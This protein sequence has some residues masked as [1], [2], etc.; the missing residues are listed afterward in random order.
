MI[1][2]GIEQDADIVLFIYRD[3][4]YNPKAEKDRAMVIVAKDRNG[5][6][7]DIN[8]RFD[9]QLTRFS[10]DWTR[11]FPMGEEALLSRNSYSEPVRVRS[12]AQVLCP[13]G[14]SRCSQTMSN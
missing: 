5:P 10:D 6:V 3:V 8:L 9:A 7:G 13:G 4:V 14:S 1:Q 12:S 2:G 11:T